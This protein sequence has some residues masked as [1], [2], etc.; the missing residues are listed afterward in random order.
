MLPNKLQNQKNYFFSA[1]FIRN[2][3]LLVLMEE[4]FKIGT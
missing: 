1:F 2:A 4:V 3:Y